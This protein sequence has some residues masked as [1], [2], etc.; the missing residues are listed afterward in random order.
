[1]RESARSTC[2]RL[3]ILLTL[4][5]NRVELRE[6]LEGAR[7][8]KGQQQPFQPPQP[9]LEFRGRPTRVVVRHTFKVV[10]A[11]LPLSDPC[12]FQV[13]RQS[14]GGGIEFTERSTV[15]GCPSRLLLVDLAK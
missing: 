15:L 3:G 12:R 10:A 14:Q 6:R 1:M 5:D 11:I 9:G 4:L 13:L 7:D 8:E 2:S